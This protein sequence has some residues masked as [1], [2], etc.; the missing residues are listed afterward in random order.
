MTPLYVDT[1]RNCLV[2]SPQ[3]VNRC[4]PPGYTV[5]DTA[6]ITLA[7]LQRNPQPLNTGQPIF[8]YVDMSAAGIVLALGSAGP[9]PAA[10]TFTVTWTGS[11][12]APLPFNCSCYDLAAAL[13]ALSS[14]SVNGGVAVQGTIGGPFTIEFL[15]PAVRAAFTTDASNLYP[16]STIGIAINTA[17]TT[18]VPARQTLT[19]GQSA[20]LT[21]N[22]FTPQS[23]AAITVTQLAANVTQRV[24]IPAGTYG[25]SFTLTVNALTT[26]ALPFASQYDLIQSAINTLLSITTATVVAGQNY[27][28][29]TIPANTHAFTGDA[30]G[31]QIPLTLTGSLAL[32]TPAVSALLVGQPAAAVPFTISATVPSQSTLY[33]GLL[34]LNAAGT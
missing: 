25:G 3:T 7:F 11:T 15:L 8:N 10:G 18:T 27:W 22:T 29:I 26:P 32:T 1:S 33:A 16:A 5:G 9:L 28:D 31:L 4:L 30:T 21:L 34:Q 17:G 14:I 6:P 2:V 23:A 13:N 24:A 19:L 12:T 20:A